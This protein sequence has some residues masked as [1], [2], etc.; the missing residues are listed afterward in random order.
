[1]TKESGTKESGECALLIVLT[2]AVPGKEEEFHRWYDTE[3]LP[4]MLKL[5]GF[6]SARRYQLSSRALPGE[7]SGGPRFLTIYEVEPG[8]VEEAAAALEGAWGDLAALVPRDALDGSV[9][10]SHR[11]YE[12]LS[13]FGRSSSAP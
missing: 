11:F 3:H 2:E 1:M 9:G 10:A 8:R 13:A 5:E 6:V 4:H 12:P 7:P